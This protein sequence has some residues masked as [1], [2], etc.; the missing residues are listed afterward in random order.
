LFVS[1]LQLFLLE[2]ALPRKEI[3]AEPLRLQNL[4]DTLTSIA[5]E[6]DSRDK[7]DEQIQEESIEEL[8]RPG[9]AGGES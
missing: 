6:I 1:H 7:E 9:G 3:E 8:H 5:P 4:E 2:H